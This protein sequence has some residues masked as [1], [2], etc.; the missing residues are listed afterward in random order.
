MLI[1]LDY[2]KTKFQKACQILKIDEQPILT[3]EEGKHSSR[4]EEF[5]NKIIINFN[6]IDDVRE[7][8]LPFIKTKLTKNIDIIMFSLY[9]ELAHCLQYQKYEKWFLNCR[10]EWLD[11]NTNINKAIIVGKEDYKKYRELKL[12][13]C[14]DKIAHILF[15]RN[16]TN[17]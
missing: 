11:F 13:K 3:F 17:E 4:Y 7:F 5:S 8:V 12:E 1:D 14:A 2:I 16:K 6:D 10:M 9:H 15:E